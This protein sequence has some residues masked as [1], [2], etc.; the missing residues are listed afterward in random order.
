MAKNVCVCCLLNLK[1]HFLTQETTQVDDG[2]KNSLEKNA[3]T[4]NFAQLPPNADP[5]D[6]QRFKIAREILKTEEDYLE[7]LTKLVQV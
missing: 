2:G 7:S 6:V 1:N 4:E 3:S 5:K